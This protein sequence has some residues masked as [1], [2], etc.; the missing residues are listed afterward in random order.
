MFVVERSGDVDGE[1]ESGTY[2]MTGKQKEKNNKPILM[3]DFVEIAQP[4][5]VAPNACC[6]VD[7]YNDSVDC[8]V[9]EG[10]RK[11]IKRGTACEQT[12]E[13]VEEVD[14]RYKLTFSINLHENL[15]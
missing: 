4:A 9:E 1:I 13:E 12:E 10:G 8:C 3:A 2:G 14:E 6:G 11:Y 5:H 15:P 7:S